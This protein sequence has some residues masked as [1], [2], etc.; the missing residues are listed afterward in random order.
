MSAADDQAAETEG[1]R[2]ARR[3]AAFWSLIVSV[4]T[5]IWLMRLWVEAGGQLQTMLFLVSDANAT[6]LL[7]TVFVTA[8]PALTGVGVA[9]LTLG[10]MLD[11]S[12]PRVPMFA[13]WFQAVPVWL[14]F[15]T[16][17]FAFA[18]WRILY[19]PLLA[20]ALVIVVQPRVPSRLSRIVLA[21]VAFAADIALW[22]V[23]YPTLNAADAQHEQLPRL[24]LAVPTVLLPILLLAFATGIPLRLPWASQLAWF[25]QPVVLAAGFW[26]VLP[27]TS[28]PVLPTT[29]TTVTQSRPAPAATG[30]ETSAGNTAAATSIRGSV[31][32]ADDRLTAILQ[33]DGGVVFVANDD[34][35]G[36]ILCPGAQDIPRY[37][38]W[39]LDLHVEDSL[40]EA[41]GRRVRP[42]APIDAECRRR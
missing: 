6:N 7:A 30:G 11:A 41:W 24:L 42:A 27:V 1:E 14:L 35:A 15:L 9:V 5:I 17:V 26:A 13:R 23:V 8:L 32:G 2:R 28:V 39:V 36:R 3:S 21:V 37:D 16:F 18:T 38:L 33:D 19:L 22:V 34:V 40:L 12:G 10:R 4:P 25:V 29:V 20:A 31:V